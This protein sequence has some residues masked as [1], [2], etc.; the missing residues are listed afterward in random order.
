[1]SI[2]LT[3]PSAQLKNDWVYG[4]LRR[5][6]RDLV[7]PPGSPLRKDELSVEFGVSRAPISEAI[8]RLADEGLVEVFPQ[9]GSFV[10]GIRLD[11]VREGMFIRMGLESQA[12]R[13]L[14]VTRSDQIMAELDSIIDGQAAALDAG[15]LTRFHDLDEALHEVIFRAVDHPRALRFLDS[16]RAQLDRLRRM[17]LPQEGRAE[18]ALREH[19]WMVEAIRLGD[20]ELAA[21]AVRAHLTSV[22]RTVE[23]QLLRLADHSGG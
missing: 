15:D 14:A 9:H 19:Q 22:T 21:A 10:A 13:E 3:P 11:D 7:L 4:V 16:A 1:M 6:I 5:R 18:A 2:A 8:A 23:Q 17:T 12:M 20:P